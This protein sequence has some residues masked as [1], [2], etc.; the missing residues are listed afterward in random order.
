MFEDSINAVK[1]ILY[2][3]I[4]QPLLYSFCLSW[5]IINYKFFIVFFGEANPQLKIELMKLYVFNSTNWYSHW[6]LKGFIYPLS[7]SLFYLFIYLP[8]IAKPIYS[9]WLKHVTEIARSKN[10][11]E[12]NQ[13]LT[14]EE[15]RKIRRQILETEIEFDKVIQDKNALI[16]DL[17]SQL[18]D[19]EKP[20]TD[21]DLSEIKHEIGRLTENIKSIQ[22]SDLSEKNQLRSKL[23]DIERNLS[24]VNQIANETPIEKL[25]KELTKKYS[26]NSSPNNNEDFLLLRIAD[27]APVYRADFYDQVDNLHKVKVDHI[28]KELTNKDYIYVDYDGEIG[29]TDQGREYLIENDMV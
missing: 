2:E 27:L 20:Q 29:L 9:H 15:S 21:K 5:I 3:R 13:L 22:N 23:D 24:I 10:E 26:S 12:E 8:K 11:I 17:K 4:S 6:T 25:E 28:L 16:D 19:N 14:I 18:L 7:G 1:A